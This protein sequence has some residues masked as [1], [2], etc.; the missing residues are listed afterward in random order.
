MGIPTAGSLRRVH[1]RL[2]RRTA[3]KQQSW[4]TPVTA[5]LPMGRRR[6]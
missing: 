6:P 3:A 4:W 5:C 2:A 1:W